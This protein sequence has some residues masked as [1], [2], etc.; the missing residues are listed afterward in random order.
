MLEI[1]STPSVDLVAR[2][3]CA[4]VAQR[5]STAQHGL[6]HVLSV[7]YPFEELH[8]QHTKT[9]TQTFPCSLPCC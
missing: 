2:R 3:Q 7:D 5:Y 4:T 6:S 9:T 1:I 8:S